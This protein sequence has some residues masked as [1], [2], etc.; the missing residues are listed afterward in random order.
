MD[1]GW[2]PGAALSPA[3]P[4]PAPGRPRRTPEERR[5]A[6]G[7]AGDR[8]CAPTASPSLR[9][10][11]PSLVVAP[12]SLL[13]PP[14]VGPRHRPGGHHR[15][16]RRVARAPSAWRPGGRPGIVR[17]PKEVTAFGF[18]GHVCSSWIP[19]TRW[20][21]AQDASSSGAWPTDEFGSRR[22]S[23]VPRPDPWT[24][25]TA[26]TRDGTRGDRRVNPGVGASGRRC[27]PPPRPLARDH[28]SLP[29]SR[30]ILAAAATKES[31]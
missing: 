29:G 3:S 17:G 2:P 30:G 8:R 12:P 9:V 13:V 11:P 28:R 20:K 18:G 31:A 23:A 15:P 22:G 24:A 16:S 7:E 14:H 19:A 26:V 21:S 1:L 10:A 25:W 6:P 27:R 4:R 5:Q